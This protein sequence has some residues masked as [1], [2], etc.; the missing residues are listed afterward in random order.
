MESLLLNNLHLFRFEI[1]AL[2]FVGL[3]M[4]GEII[5][6]LAFYL[7]RQHYLDFGD[8]LII[9]LAGVIIG[10][11]L[12]YFFGKYVER[13][14]LLGRMIKKI[15]ASVDRFILTRPALSIIVSKFTYGF[16]RPVLLKLYSAKVKY[17]QFILI[18]LV[19]VILW[20][21]VYS[22]LG[23]VLADSLWLF[24]H[25]IKYWELAF[26]IAIIVISLLFKLVSDFV[27]RKVFKTN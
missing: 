25:Q 23:Y 16:H 7:A 12:W 27:K 1:Y 4:E 26:V 2:L 9:A 22:I 18:D 6:F 14:P 24:R 13:A 11:N 5:L 10:D 8:T 17:R 21:G 3:L 19:G 15:P 20:V